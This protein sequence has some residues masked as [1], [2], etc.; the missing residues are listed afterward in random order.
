M[1]VYC[2]GSA[3]SPFFKGT[4]ISTELISFTTLYKLSYESICG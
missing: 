4:D 2:K 3:I 1:F